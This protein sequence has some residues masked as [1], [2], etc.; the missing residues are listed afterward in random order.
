MGKI[1]DLSGIQ[2]KVLNA[3]KG[4]AVQGPRAQIDRDLYKEN[5]QDYLTQ[6]APNLEI[7]EA[8][9]FWNL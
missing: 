1:A 3:S 6:N 2:F 8:R 4:V 9:Y 5:M 7:K